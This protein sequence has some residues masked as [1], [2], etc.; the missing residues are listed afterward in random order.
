[1]AEPATIDACLRIAP[2]FDTSEHGELRDQLRSKLEPRLARWR[3]DQVELE[4]S[5]KDRDSDQQKV[6]LEAWIAARGDTRFVG[7]ST[8]PVLRTAV[9]EARDDVHRQID[10]FLGRRET[11][12]RG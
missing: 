10:R 8:N 1:M 4:L 6:T 9:N 12:R 2:Q 5:V 11:R 3:A 7:T